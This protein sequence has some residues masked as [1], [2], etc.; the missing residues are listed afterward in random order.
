MTLAQKIA[1]DDAILPFQLD[2]ADMRGR[3][4]RLDAVLDG[5]LGH[6]D[7]PPPVRELVA[8][9]ALLCALIG[10]T[11]KLRWK[12][13]LQLRGE[14]PVRI[15]AAD[16]FAPAVPGEA[17]RMRAYAGYERGRID[18]AAPGFAQLGRGVFGVLIDQGPGSEPYQGITP[19]AGGS[20]AACAETYFAQ[21]EQLPTRFALG[22]GRVRDSDGRGHWRAGGIMIQHLPRTPPRIQGGG[23]GER[24]LLLAEDVI[25]DE[26]AQ[27]WRRVTGALERAQAED[28]LGPEVS[29]ADLLL[30]L[31]ADE[32]PR[33][34]DGQPV[35]FGCTCSEQR[36]R[37]SLAACTAQEIASMTTA[38]GVVTADCQFCGAHY[39][40]DP[41]TLG[42]DA[43]G[44]AA[45]TDG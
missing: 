19:L 10:Q 30:R 22:H 36:V 13:S 41:A 31:F 1:W 8:E 29:P 15:I 45:G 24:G 3:M 27:S 35:R 12:L 37:R 26:G 11:I 34:Y 5:I 28:L 4:A 16:Y 9:L 43:A 7:H 21:S 14:G 40:L 39:E 44:G 20:L 18:A 17:A 32:V 33:V 38:A 6:Q 23:S 25:G 2:A 42:A